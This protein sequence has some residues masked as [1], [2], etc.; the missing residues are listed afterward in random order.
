MNRNVRLSF[1]FVI[2]LLQGMASW[3]K[4]AEKPNVLWIYLEDVSRR[5]SCYGDKIVE[6]P[7]IDA[8]AADGIRFNR[9]Y[10]P[11]GVCSA[12]E[13]FFHA[14]IHHRFLSAFV[15]SSGRSDEPLLT[16]VFLRTNCSVHH[17]FLPDRRLFLAQ[18]RRRT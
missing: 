2:V 5:F 1:F 16:F 9:F 14:R 18:P 17:S 15:V 3:G 13:S 11:A 7:N 12:T 10:T 6:T 4:A 8:L